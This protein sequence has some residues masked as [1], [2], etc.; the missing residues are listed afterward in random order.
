MLK[1]SSVLVTS[2][3]LIICPTLSSK[4]KNLSFLATKSVSEFNSNNTQSFPSITYEQS[5]SAATLEAFFSAFAIPFSRNQTIAFSI[6][7]SQASRAFL[8][9]I[10]PA[11]VL[12]RN[13]FTSCGVTV[14]V[15]L[16]K[17]FYL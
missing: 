14:M 15:I 16:L 7:Q 17:Y 9:S 10:I 1:A 12:S 2:D 6:S 5:P 13:S 8:Q 3:A 4:A 11:I